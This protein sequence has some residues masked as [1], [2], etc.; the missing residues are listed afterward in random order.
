MSTLIH[1]SGEKKIQNEIKNRLS[2]SGFKY[3]IL[4]EEYK[5]L[6]LNKSHKYL[7]LD[8][9]ND[10][11]TEIFKGLKHHIKIHNQK[12]IKDFSK[13]Y[14]ED[15]IINLILNDFINK[16]DA[17]KSNT[18][19]YK[20]VFNAGYSSIELRNN[21]NTK[22][23][24]SYNIISF[25]NY[26][27]NEYTIIKEKRMIG[28][29]GLE[30]PDFAMYINGIPL[31]VWE[32]KTKQTTLKK[33][34]KEFGLKDTYS[35]F[36]LC[37][38]TDG[39]EAFLTGSKKIFFKWKKY[40]K[41]INGNYIFKIESFLMK[42]KYTLE[43]EDKIQNLMK[44]QVPL[45]KKEEL[46]NIIK[47]HLKEKE[48]SNI[49]FEN[50]SKYLAKISIESP[51]K[52][53]ILIDQIK[54]YLIVPTKGIYDIIEELFD[55]PS[56][57]L[58][59]FKYGVMIDKSDKGS[60]ENHF[61]INHRVQQ[62]YTIK[63]LD[64]K[65][66][67]I[68]NRNDLKNSLMSEL[69]KHVQRSGKS[70]TI[71]SAVNLIADKY[72]S[73]FRKIYICVPDLTILNVMIDTFQNNDLKV[74][75][76]QSRNAFIKSIN[77][78]SSTF[79]VYLYNIQ[80]TKE[81]DAYDTG[82]SKDD[83]IN[84]GEYKENNA[85]FII[86]E[87]HFSQSSSQADI[88]ERAFPNASFLTFTATPKIKELNGEI[89]NKTA[90]RYSESDNDGKI[91][92]L[93]ELNATE[94]INMGIILPVV[95]EK[96]IFEQNASLQN[97][98]EFDKK[99][100]DL[101]KEYLNKSEYA[102]KIESDKEDAEKMVRNELE[103]KVGKE[104]TSQILD[105]QIQEAKIDV[106]NK[107]IG[108]AL[109]EIEKI[110]KINAF[111]QLRTFKIEYVIEDII[112]KRIACYSDGDKAHFRT[113]SFFVVETQKEAQRYME[114]V[115]KLSGNDTTTYKNIRFGADFSE[116]QRSTSEV[117]VL[118][119][120]NQLNEN[121][122]TIKKFE[123]QNEKDNPID[124][125]FIVNKYLMGYDNKELVAVYCDKIINEP[126]KLYQL[127]TRSATTREGKE[128]GFFIDLNFG[129]E[130]YKTYTEKCLP[131]YNNNSGTSISTLK[132]EEILIQKVLLKNKILEIKKLLGYE[133]SDL[134]IDELDIYNKLL[135]KGSKVVDS[136]IAIKKKVDYFNKFREINE[137]MKV[138]IKPRYYM[139]NF[140]EILIL[141]KV[142]NRYLD[143]GLPKP[144]DD[145]IFDKEDIKN[146]ILKSLSFFGFN[147]LE[148]INRF[149]INGSNIKDE[150]LIG[151]VE[152]NNVL[153]DFKQTLTLSRSETPK[154][155][156]DLINKWT[157]QI[158]SSADA[159]IAIS[160]LKKDFIIPFNEM[161]KKRSNSIINEY[162]GLVSWKVSSEAMNDAFSIIEEIRSLEGFTDVK[163]NKNL[164]LIDDDF[165]DDFNVFLKEYSELLSKELKHIISESDLS[166]F[167]KQSFYINKII[168]NISIEL[169]DI[170]CLKMMDNLTEEKVSAIKKAFWTDTK[171]LK[172]IMQS[173]RA[174][175]DEIKN[176]SL[177]PSVGLGNIW[178]LFM[179]ESYYIELRN[180]TLDEKEIV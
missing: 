35:K 148:E 174:V 2:N 102:D 117:S 64:K 153:S 112:K 19:Y 4:D 115:K 42:N 136:N 58:F 38:G 139:E 53:Y 89:I 61:L 40:G 59:Y 78:S 70:I 15:E 170:S 109:R 106:Y 131:Y 107:Y 169:K 82:F 36:I 134:L 94:A 121:E 157:E 143:E 5:D 163:L 46:V 74:K 167:E 85:L 52:K 111:N 161:K 173:G 119:E 27:D 144:T 33:A 118:T 48:K 158:M 177:S 110:E 116:T 69:V 86:D 175:N 49:N 123:S 54:S 96:V 132:K 9:Y 159:D 77:D 1:L 93:D 171:R 60:D 18:D 44:N 72:R 162:N 50:I 146:I 98:V 20:L 156:T 76:I 114:V 16:W 125:L 22:V 90:I 28:K 6:N 168:N 133:E 62:Y 126:A 66:K 145:F 30:Q 127:I 140:D 55:S 39:D 23:M 83:F 105:E 79:T 68:N 150:K 11:N 160:Q 176:I 129:N 47:S 81:P 84:I 120:L 104:I 95:Y 73:L 141:S 8:S 101:V 149:K 13:N 137:I 164:S 10:G 166:I 147:D 178:V 165:K 179:F 75:R 37:L 128:Q 99:T 154:G 87:V 21:K 56:N 113:K 17:A 7:L 100:N 88:R 103:S 138:L 155:L 151:R 25:N 71:R 32:V 180:K 135:S 63:A 124:V 14:S 34:L 172:E 142:N 57:L 92:Y 122:K 65:L 3:N 12:L 31:I 130:N 26:A 51:E 97:A 41:N 152:F 108:K 45:E 24:K 43:D 29:N 80:K 91:Y 67:N